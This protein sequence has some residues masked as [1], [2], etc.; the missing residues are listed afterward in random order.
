MRKMKNKRN[1]AAIASTEVI[2]RD[3]NPAKFKR[4]L[5]RGNKS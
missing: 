3:L 5:Y 2:N 1:E 4:V